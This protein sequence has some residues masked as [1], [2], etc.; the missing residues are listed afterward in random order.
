MVKY[1]FKLRNSFSP[2]FSG[3]KKKQRKMGQKEAQNL[4]WSSITVLY[5]KRLSSKQTQT[6][7]QVIMMSMSHMLVSV[8][9]E[10]PKK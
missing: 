2:K 7:A 10:S 5:R 9:I 8:S 1:S 3:K 4:F 6:Q